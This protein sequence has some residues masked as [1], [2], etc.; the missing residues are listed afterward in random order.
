LT[1][2]RRQHILNPMR[3]LAFLAL[4]SSTF[5]AVG[6]AQQIPGRDLLEFPIGTLADPPALALHLADGFSNPASILVGPG[7]RGR[8]GVATLD[9]GRDQGVS[10]QVLGVAAAMPSETT[11][12]L[13][14]VRA[15]VADLVR[16]ETDPQ[17]VGN[18]VPYSTTVLSALVARRTRGHFVSG[19][20]LRYRSGELD[21][22]RGSAIGLDA[23][24]I[25]DGLFAADGRVAVS[26]YLWRPGAGS[27]DR[28]T[29]NVAGDARVTGTDVR[30]EARLGYGFSYTPYRT[31]EHYYFG[32][33]RSGNWEGS[34]G[35]GRS[36][37]FNQAT[38]RVRL[39]LDLHYG[40]YLVGIARED[41]GS[42]LAP[43]Y[44][45]AL[46]ATVR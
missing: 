34:A 15:S 20:A 32:S 45:F 19:L 25:A 42:G 44:Q 12:A 37:T 41:T 26:S 16:T 21:G 17:S 2:E 8:I 1:G 29:L 9:A 30:H 31:R 36:I 6:G 7:A 33:A 4:V 28:A 23:G 35:I 27:A 3:R 14:L 46:T 40:R 22:L 18:D 11:V 5:T 10:A 13:S 43:T 38:N 39:G 24:L